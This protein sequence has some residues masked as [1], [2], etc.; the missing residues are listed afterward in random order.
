MHG[1][2]TIKNGK[3]LA[4][5]LL[6]TN[7]RY[8]SAASSHTDRFFVH[9]RIHKLGDLCARR[10]FFFRVEFSNFLSTFS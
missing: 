4:G 3:M 5:L 9:S 6:G 2:T 10:Y 8:R 7:M 1:K